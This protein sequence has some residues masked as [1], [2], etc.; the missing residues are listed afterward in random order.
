MTTPN[1][2]QVSQ[3]RLAAAVEKMP[4]FPKAVQQVLALC[5]DINCSPRQLVVVIEHDPVLTV[6]LLRIVNSASYG[7]PN[8]V[9]SVNQA[10][11]YLGLNT[12]KNLALT[13]A[14]IGVLPAKNVAGF[15]VGEYLLHS[16]AVASLARYLATRP[17]SGGVDGDDAYVAGLLHDFGKVVMATHLPDEYR[18][19][20]TT[21]DAEQRPLHIVERQLI[22][23]D[24][25]DVGAM[26]AQHWQFSSDLVS[27]IRT[28]QSTPDA[29]GL[30]ACVAM[31]NQLARRAGV[32]NARNT[33][34][35]DEKPVT[36]RWGADFAS[37]DAAL[38]SLDGILASA[39]AFAESAR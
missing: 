25:A 5:R 15:D 27:C 23:A 33:F 34:R 21:A 16:V 2:Q 24:H 31:A 28:H 11:L 4:A 7:L 20:L 30:T 32:G 3:Q 37:I 17:E 10:V 18:E 14:M 38:G 12:V 13:F 35:K 6:K 39:R 1:K 9:A 22:G 19:A 26:L 36:E 8:K 29:D